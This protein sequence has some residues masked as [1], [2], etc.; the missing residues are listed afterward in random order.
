VVKWCKLY[1]H[2]TDLVGTRSIKLEGK[3]KHAKTVKISK[4]TPELAQV[5]EMVINEISLV[6][7]KA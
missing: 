2:Y 1:L 7:A 3:G 5:I 4:L 6:A